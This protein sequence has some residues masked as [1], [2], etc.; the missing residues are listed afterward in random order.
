[1]NLRRGDDPLD[2]YAPR[3]QRLL[4]P[5]RGTPERID[6]PTWLRT[7]ERKRRRL[8]RDGGRW[9]R[10]SRPQLLRI[11]LASFRLEGIAIESTLAEDAAATRSRRGGVR[12]RLAQRLRTHLAILL[13]IERSLRRVEPLK[14]GSVLHWYT[15]LAHG[16]S[17]TMLADE[18]LERL[19]HFVRRINSPHLRL[20]PAI[21]EIVSLHVQALADELVPSF[22][23]MIARLL[24]HYHLGRCGLPPVTFDPARDRPHLLDQ[25]VLLAR[26]LELVNGGFDELLATDP[27]RPAHDA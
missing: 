10:L 16:L 22:N 15:L 26:V 4:V 1:M 13:R 25:P 18:K 19:D 3:E 5:S 11:A 23:G 12:T 2:R 14:S 27:R 8:I 20:Q 9:Q 17:T 21:Q 6:W 24:L 7:I